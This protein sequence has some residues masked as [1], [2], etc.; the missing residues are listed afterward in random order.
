MVLELINLFLHSDVAKMEKSCLN[1]QV[2]LENLLIYCDK[3][4]IFGLLTFTPGHLLSLC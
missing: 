1:S 2:P 3:I 4:P